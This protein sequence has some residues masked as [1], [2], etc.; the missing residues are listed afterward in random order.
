MSYLSVIA[1]MHKLSMVTL[2]PSSFVHASK[3][4]QQENH[5]KIRKDLKLVFDWEFGQVY[6]LR[7]YYLLRW[8]KNMK[9]CC[10]LLLSKV[11]KDMLEI[12]MKKI[13]I[14]SNKNLWVLSLN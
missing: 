2:I 4:M 13:Q 1:S 6:L 5:W 9:K 12:C 3:T 11:K 8:H 14:I 10:G 7:L